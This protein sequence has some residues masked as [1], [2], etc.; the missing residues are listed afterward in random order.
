[1]IEK[2]SE[3]D[4]DLM[5]KYLGGEDIPEEEIHKVIRRGTI[6]GEIYPIMLVRLLKMWVFKKF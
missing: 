3:L 5:E 2:I 1:M 6:A 4:D